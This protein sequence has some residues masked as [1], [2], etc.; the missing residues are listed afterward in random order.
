MTLRDIDREEGPRPSAPDG[1]LPRVMAPQPYGTLAE[2]YEWLVPDSLLTPEGTVAAFAEV[3][4]ALPPGASV[5]DCAAGIGQLAVG[6]RLRGFDVTATDASP[7]MV[8]RTKA[9]AAEHGVDVRAATCRW[10]EIGDQGWSGTFDA[11]FCV[12]NALVHASGTT[13]RQH[14]LGQ[15]AGTLRPGGVLVVTSRNWE[16]VRERGSGVRIGEKLVE[17]HGRRGVIVYAWTIPERWNERHDLDVAVAFLDSSGA[18]TSAG[19][20][21]ELWPFRHEALEAE[22]RAAGL[23]AQTST[24]APE[25]E[26]YLVTARRAAGA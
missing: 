6:L 16:L 11:V 18:V 17:R 3:V 15:M 24:Y 20:R 13:A 23:A 14:A 22:L 10:D 9:L 8:E 7:A 26:R 19:E 25:A 21:L 12:G 1:T 4:D 5:L 2:V